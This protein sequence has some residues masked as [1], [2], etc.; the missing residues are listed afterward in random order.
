VVSATSNA[1][2]PMSAPREKTGLK[3]ASARTFGSTAARL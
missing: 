2:K 3:G 1:T